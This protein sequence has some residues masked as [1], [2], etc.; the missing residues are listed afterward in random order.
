MGLISNNSL[1]ENIDMFMNKAK[2]LEEQNNSEAYKHC[3]KADA[4]RI[5]NYYWESIE[6][7]LIALSLDESNFEALKGMGL[8]YKKIGYIRC[9]V[10]SLE[11]A[12]N[13]SPF[14]KSVYNELGKCYIQLNQVDLALKRF[15]RAIKLDENYTDAKFNLAVAHEYADEFE[16]AV[17]IY[18]KVIADR[19][20]FIS[21]YNNLAS[22]YMRMDNLSES[23]VYF[24]KLLQINPDFYRA[25]LGI[26][27]SLD[28]LDQK[29]ESIRYYKKYME[30]KPNSGNI[31][32]IKT[33]INDIMSEIPLSNKNHLKLVQIV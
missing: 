20:S 3:I 8:S 10:E 22:L 18:L 30:Y 26:A 15:R 5:K 28:K 33:R 17:N 16:M 4:L 31:P 29:R 19:P 24:K 7:Y 11:K 25:Y 27:V 2:S 6:E 21:A 23:I 14:D 32:Y 13:L 1:P 9:A 12:K